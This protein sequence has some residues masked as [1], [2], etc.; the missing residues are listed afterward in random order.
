M[1]AAL[2][3]RAQ[4]VT[5]SDGGERACVMVLY[6]ASAAEDVVRFKAA[7]TRALE[8]AGLTS[9]LFAKTSKEALDIL[10]KSGG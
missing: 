8:G 9:L 10:L 5:V 6:P 7:L 4:S 3:V 2:G 1:V